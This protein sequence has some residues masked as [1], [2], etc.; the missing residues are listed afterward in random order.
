MLVTS[1]MKHIYLK[2]IVI[3]AVRSQSQGKRIKGAGQKIQLAFQVGGEENVL[4][5]KCCG[6]TEKLLA[7]DLI[8][9]STNSFPVSKTPN[10]RN[11]LRKKND[12]FRKRL[13]D[14]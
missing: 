9:G 14:F 2:P 3:A 4:L 6:I 7:S 13:Y 1:N 8:Y 10:N 11:V 12:I 5:R